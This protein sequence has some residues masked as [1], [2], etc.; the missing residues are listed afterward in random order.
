MLGRGMVHPPDLEGRVQ[1]GSGSAIEQP[2]SL[3]GAGVEAGVGVVNQ[4]V[5]E[6]AC[7]L[8]V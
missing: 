6:W 2:A 4:Q 7:F 5:L 1:Q 3:V 8:D